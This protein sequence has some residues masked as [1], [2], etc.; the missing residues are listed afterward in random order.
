MLSLFWCNL[1]TL[2]PAPVLDGVTSS[3][4][5]LAST[6]H[7]YEEQP[8][9]SLCSSVSRSLRTIW[10]NVKQRSDNHL[11]QRYILSKFEID[12]GTILNIAVNCYDSLLSLLGYYPKK[13][14]VMPHLRIYAL[15]HTMYQ[16]HSTCIPWKVSAK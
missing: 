14:S 7:F 13:L 1:I 15:S 3:L 2:G 16:F 12:W 4:Q 11:K 6:C 8:M 10:S 9:T 5:R